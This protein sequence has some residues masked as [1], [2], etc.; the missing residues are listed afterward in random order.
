[1]ER[2]RGA[3]RSADRG[4]ERVMHVMDRQADF[5]R[6]EALLVGAGAEFVIRG[7]HMER[8]LAD[9][10]T[11]EHA[12]SGLTAR[13]TRE[14]PLSKRT[15]LRPTRTAN[16]ERRARTAE[17]LVGT[18]SVTIKRSWATPER[19]APEFDLNV[20]HVWEEKAPDGE[21]AVEWTLLTTL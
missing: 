4:R 8:K 19:N 14:V 16:P 13:L 9:G 7:S 10:R 3:C 20:V 5:Y 18:T 6:L 21:P 11:L 17:L 15:P 1:M 2:G 12:T